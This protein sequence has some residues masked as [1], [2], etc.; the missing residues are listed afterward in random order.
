MV[1]RARSRHLQAGGMDRL[2]DGSRALDDLGDTSL[3]MR[4]LC[5]LT[6][7]VS[8]IEL[9]TD[10]STARGFVGTEN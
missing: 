5:H 7:I 3:H 2:A 8:P 10:C 1:Y 6:L 9:Q 4:F